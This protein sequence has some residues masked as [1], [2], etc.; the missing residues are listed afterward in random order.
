M[1]HDRCACTAPQRL[2]EEDFPGA[3][4]ALAKYADL[5]HD[6][7]VELCGFKEF[8][9]V[10][11][12]EASTSYQVRAVASACMGR[13]E[14]RMTVQG[15]FLICLPILHA[16][17]R[18]TCVKQSPDGSSSPL[19]AVIGSPETDEDGQ[20]IGVAEAQHVLDIFGAVVRALSVPA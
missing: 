7:L 11:F 4:E 10:E 5:V 15:L 8:S 9:H 12:L 2:P 19:A 16:S 20:L 14:N 18:C 6:V 13:R 3:V 17:A 1:L